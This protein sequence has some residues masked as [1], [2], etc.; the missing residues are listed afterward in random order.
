MK[1]RFFWHKMTADS[2]LASSRYFE[3]AIRVDP[4]YALAHAGLADCY[5]Q[6]GSFRVALIRP[7]M[8]LAKATTLAKRALE[9]DPEL[10]EA[11]N[12]L[13]LVKTWY[14]CDWAGAGR[15]FAMRGP[16]QPKCAM[17]FRCSASTVR[18][19]P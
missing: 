4:D 17:I 7:T 18:C 8:A 3:Q 16:A 12:A 9:L 10:P 19:S 2:V 6:M 13:A 11:H 14:E 1:G 5:S 15:A